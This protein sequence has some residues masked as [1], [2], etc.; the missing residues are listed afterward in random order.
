MHLHK[1]FSGVLLHLNN[2]KYF[3]S[4][5]NCSAH[6]DYSVCKYEAIKPGPKYVM[7]KAPTV[8]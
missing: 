7:E 1:L 3:F 2:M 8:T 5:V 6:L 4:F